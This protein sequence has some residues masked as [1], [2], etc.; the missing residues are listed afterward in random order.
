M[1]TISYVVLCIGASIELQTMKLVRFL[2]TA[3]GI[4]PGAAVRLEQSGAGATVCICPDCWV[5]NDT[6]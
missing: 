4:A 2:A 1:R 5:R 3:V 6:A